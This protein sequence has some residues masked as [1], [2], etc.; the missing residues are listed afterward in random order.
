MS[1]ANHWRLQK[2]RLP[3]KQERGRVPRRAKPQDRWQCR[4]AAA[5]STWSCS[6][7]ARSSSGGTARCTRTPLR[8]TD[9]RGC[10]LPRDT[11]NHRMVLKHKNTNASRYKHISESQQN[12][13][14]PLATLPRH[15]ETLRPF[16]SIYRSNES[17]AVSRFR[18][19]PKARRPQS[20]G[21][22]HWSDNME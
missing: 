4:G 20:H 17:K 22:R 7:R 5:V 14:E 18:F 6:D 19:Y 21:V 12:E 16:A 15:N 1:R 8:A 13:G 3:W 10:K 11:R 9:Q 2:L